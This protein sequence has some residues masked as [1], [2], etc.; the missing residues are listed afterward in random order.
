[1]GG[2]PSDESQTFHRSRSAGRRMAQEM[3]HWVMEARRS[4]SP[5]DARVVLQAAIDFLSETLANSG[6]PPESPER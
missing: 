4:D 2:N 6:P 3:V 1:M 5:V